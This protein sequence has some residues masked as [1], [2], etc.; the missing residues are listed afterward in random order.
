MQ[1]L[2]AIEDPA[3]HEAWSTFLFNPDVVRA[4]TEELQG[5]VEGATAILQAGMA[6]NGQGW[7][8]G[9]ASRKLWTASGVTLVSSNFSDY[10]NAHLF[11]LC[12]LW[13]LE[14][15]QLDLPQKTAEA[16]FELLAPYGPVVPPEELAPQGGGEANTMEEDD[17]DDHGMSKRSHC[18]GN[19]PSC[20]PVLKVVPSDWS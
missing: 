13:G 9:T 3:Y 20:G 5:D 12:L 2:I 19:W 11:A 17:D 14:V 18:P 15:A 10:I 16:A 1:A 8:T 4:V 7:T 6:W